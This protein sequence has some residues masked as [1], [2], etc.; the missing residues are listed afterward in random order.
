[1]NEM[2]SNEFRPAVFPADIMWDENLDKTE[3]WVLVVLFTYTNAHT[4]T[5]FPAYQTIAD[6][7]AITRRAAINVVERLI[8]KGYITKEERYKRDSSGKILQTSNTYIIH[9]K[10]KTPDDRELNSPPLV[11][12][13]HPGSEPRS[14]P[15]V[16]VVHPGSEPRSPELSNE[17][18]NIT[19]EEAKIFPREYLELAAEV[20]ATEQDLA[21]AIKK[22]DE[23]T[24]L[25]SHIAWLTEALKREK[26]NRELASRPKT[27]KATSPTKKQ[28]QKTTQQ[29]PTSP[30][31]YEKFYL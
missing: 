16:N 22:M 5:V 11:N 31:K 30:S 4:N 13:V 19:E 25:D 29:Q 18:S 20:G 10:P 2:N 6:R 27:P 26:L 1:M 28:N 7:A 23:K 15:P 24:D 3:R 12:V 8:K 21:A 17:L 14:L 9:F